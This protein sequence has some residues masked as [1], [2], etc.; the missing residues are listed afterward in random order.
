MRESCRRCLRPVALCLCGELSP[1][2]SRTRV[3]I[4]QHPREARLAICSAWLAR[5]ALENA[6][7]HQG[8][9][10]DALPRVR[11]V[12]ADPRAAASPYSLPPVREN[13]RR[14]LRPVALCLC[15]DLAPA[16]S[17]TR[18]VIFQHPR[19]ARLAICSAWLA[20]VALENAEL[21]QAVDLDAHPRVRELCGEPGAA[22]LFPGQGSAAAALRAGSPPSHLGVVDGTW[23]QAERMIG[24][25]RLL[26]ALPRLSV[27]PD[28]GEGY[29][30]LR[31]EPG[32]HCLSTLEAIALAL[33]ALEGDAG[34]FAPMRAAFRRMV[35]G[36]LEC[37][38]GARR[39]PRHRPG[40]AKA[41]ALGTL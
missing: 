32:A 26:A 24:R 6:E 28:G 39:S 30:D 27:E 15:A 10:L 25:S 13:C 22:L 36:Q 19:E 11:E 37:A 41:R 16:P 14:C 17:R 35:S 4:L 5:L 34:R 33:S 40:R 20:R 38:R 1:A 18:V 8:V 7:L 31:R 29:G 21:H 9:D 2:P 23:H 12:C 3:V